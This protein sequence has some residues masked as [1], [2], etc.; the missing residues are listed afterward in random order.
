MHNH[1]VSAVTAGSASD[2]NGLLWGNPSGRPAPN[3]FANASGTPQYM[4]PSALS[5]SGGSQPHNNLMPYLVMNFCI[6][7]QGVFPPRT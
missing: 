5:V 6:A 7:L 1:T 4:N 3:F 2:P